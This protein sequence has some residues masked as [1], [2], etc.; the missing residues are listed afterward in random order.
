MAQIIFFGRPVFTRRAKQVL[1]G[2]T[3]LKEDITTRFARGEELDLEDWRVVAFWAQQA[4]ESQNYP[5]F[6]LLQA[7]S[8]L[9]E[10]R[11]HRAN[12]Y[13][14]D[15]Y[16]GNLP[17]GLR[18]QCDAPKVESRVRQLTSLTLDM[19]TKNPDAGLWPLLPARNLSAMLEFDR[20]IDLRGI[21]AALRPFGH[22]L[23]TAASVAIDQRHKG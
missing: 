20:L 7:F 15:Y 10:W 18:P 12:I 16:L 22:D 13:N 9:F 11:D 21:N 23:F 17:F 14:C 6:R 3:S 8:A 1:G 4:A 5:Q 2:E 19:L